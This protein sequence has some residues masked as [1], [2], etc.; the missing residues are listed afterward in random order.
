MTEQS[1]IG[2]TGS[3]TGKFAPNTSGEV[4]VHIRGG[5]EYY[6]ARSVDGRK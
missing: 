2:D 1:L 3:I 6:F 4:V 5:T